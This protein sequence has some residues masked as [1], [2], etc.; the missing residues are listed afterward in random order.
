MPSN[1]LVVVPPFARDVGA[2]QNR[3]AMI[4]EPLNL[5]AVMRGISFQRGKGAVDFPLNLL[6][7]SE[8][9]RG[10][11]RTYRSLGVGGGG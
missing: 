5:Y 1:L 8:K 4:F 11:G 2:E 3:S 10:S 6:H 7:Q 9:Q